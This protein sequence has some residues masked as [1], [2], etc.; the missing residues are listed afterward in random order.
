[1]NNTTEIKSLL[2][3][4]FERINTNFA[5]TTVAKMLSISCY[6]EIIH[7]RKNQLMWQTSSL[8]Y[9]KEWPQPSQPLTTTTP[10][11]P[12]V[13]NT[14][15]RPSTSKRLQLPEASDDA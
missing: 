15:A 2:M 7:E 10:I 13:I 11:K 3:N 1:M 14:E 12:A 6:R 5:S 4:A 9:F 8:S